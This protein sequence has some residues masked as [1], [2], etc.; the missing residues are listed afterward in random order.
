[1]NLQCTLI[2]LFLIAF[3]S[4][5]LLPF[6]AFF[7]VDK[8]QADLQHLL[9]QKVNYE[10]C[11]K[12]LDADCKLNERLL[13]QLKQSEAEEQLKAVANAS[14]AVAPPVAECDS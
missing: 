7:A 4:K 11:L 12:E 2:S 8:L 9:D 6:V 14:S 10:R 3:L 5:T 1:M 13:T